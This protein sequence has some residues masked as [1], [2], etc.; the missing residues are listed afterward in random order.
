MNKP[1]VGVIM[2]SQSDWETM[3]QAANLLTE[4][5]IKFESK[6]VSA[7]RTPDRLFNYGLEATKKGLKIIIVF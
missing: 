6:I 4:L 3:K 5:E 1:Q 2:G 7:H